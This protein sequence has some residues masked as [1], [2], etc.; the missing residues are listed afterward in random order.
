VSRRSLYA[1]PLIA[2]N[3]LFTD[4]AAISLSVAV[5]PP[6]A[7]LLHVLV[8]APWACLVLWALQHRILPDAL[9]AWIGRQE[10]RLGERAQRLLRWGKRPAVL[11]TAASMGPLSALIAIRVL[12]FAPRQRYALAVA[13]AAAYCVVWT[14]LVYSGGWLLIQRLLDL[15][16]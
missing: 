14:G 3:S 16:S 2:I 4:V 5:G 12:G 11:L 13:A 15:R 7:S 1:L 9:S 8:L 6:W 10:Q